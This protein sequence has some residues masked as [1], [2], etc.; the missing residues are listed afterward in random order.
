MGKFRCLAGKSRRGLRKELWTSACR[1][2]AGPSD[3]HSGRQSSTLSTTVQPRN[4]DSFTA[5]NDRALLQHGYL[6]VLD[7][8]PCSHVAP[9]IRAFT[10]THVQGDSWLCSLA[11]LPFTFDRPRTSSHGSSSSRSH[12]VLQ[13]GAH[14]ACTVTGKQSAL[15]CYTT[16]NASQP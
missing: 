7:H 8:G 13:S 2:Q 10:I 12:P 16:G 1:S 14:E 15:Y 9:S 6:N 3:R 11:L 5:S 4:L